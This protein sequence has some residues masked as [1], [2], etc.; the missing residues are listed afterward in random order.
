MIR[1]R[2]GLTVA[3]ALV[4]ASCA[5]G[6]TGTAATG[7]GRVDQSRLTTDELRTDIG[8]RNLYDFITRA[9]PHWLSRR[10]TQ[11]TRDQTDIVVYRDGVRLGGRETLRDISVDIVESVRLLSGSEAAS[12]FGLDHQFGAILVVTGRS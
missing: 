10:P 1:L 4:V 3:L 9:R 7:G 5:S 11:T 2:S 12:R 8:A 6:A